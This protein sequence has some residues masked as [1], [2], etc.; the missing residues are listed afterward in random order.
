MNLAIITHTTETGIN[1]L[2]TMEV[3]NLVRSEFDSIKKFTSPLDVTANDIESVEKI[4][5]IVPEWNGSFPYTFKQ[6]LDNSGWPSFFKGKSILLIG[7]SNTTFGN[8]IGLTHLQYV[9]EFC[10]SLVHNQKIAIPHLQ[11][12][13]ANND[14]V[15]NQEVNKWIREFCSK[16]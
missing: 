6:M 14:I 7:T 13:F 5:M 4:I 16:C 12:K 11:G 3:I 2:Q 10:G 9:L 1:H 8:I 15:V